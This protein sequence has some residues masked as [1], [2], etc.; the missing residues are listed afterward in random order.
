MHGL[1][2]QIHR[3]QSKIAY[4]IENILV[5]VRND[6]AQFLNLFFVN[7]TADYCNF[8]QT[9]IHDQRVAI[10]FLTHTYLPNYSQ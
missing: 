2:N 7:K 1:C 9:N 4:F 10:L 3:S 6:F 5:I 8:Q